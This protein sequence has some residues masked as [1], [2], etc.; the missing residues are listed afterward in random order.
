MGRREQ[1]VLV[2]QIGF[3]AV[4][5]DEVH[6]LLLDL[7]VGEAGHDWAVHRALGRRIWVGVDQHPSERRRV[8]GVGAGQVSVL[9]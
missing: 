4:S 6:Q 3:E 1:E 9:C 2:A 7:G 8:A 5:G